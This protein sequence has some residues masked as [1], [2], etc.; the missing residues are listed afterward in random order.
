[1]RY[2]T[3]L[4]DLDGTLL[5]FHK[6]QKATFFDCFP[7]AT[8]ALYDRYEAINLA[9]WQ[10]LERGEATRDEILRERFV[11]FL[12]ETNL[13]GEPDELNRRYLDRLADGCDLI[14]GAREAL[15]QL[16]KTCTL[17]AVTNGISFVQKRRLRASGLMG[18]FR[19]VLISE[20][21]GITKP[22]PRFFEKAMEIGG[23]ADPRKV[24]VVG[25]SL[26]ADIAGG[27]AAGL[28]TCWFNPEKKPIPADCAPT[29]V[30]HDT[31]GIV[32]AA[33]GEL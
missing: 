14:D 31:M 3:L 23:A 25:D 19:A 16:A 8:E 7:G 27:A 4:L 10:R 20:E 22:D 30:V 9:Q 6:S 13:P 5:D 15:E 18:Y 32:K 17:I 28:D 33:A 21:I 11:R 12:R 29:W 2:T 1:M 26:T 24:L